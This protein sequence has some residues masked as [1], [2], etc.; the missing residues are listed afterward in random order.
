MESYKD[1][2]FLKKNT[3]IQKDKRQG[4]KMQLRNKK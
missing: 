4:N 3:I 1:E 2:F